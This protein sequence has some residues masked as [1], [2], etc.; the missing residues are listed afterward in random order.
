MDLFRYT[1]LSLAAL[2]VCLLMPREAQG[3]PITAYPY[4]ESFDASTSLPA[5]W[6]TDAGDGTEVW[7]VAASGA[8]EPSFGAEVDHTS[9]AGNLL[10]VDDSGPNN[11]INT[12]L[13]TPV[14][15][16]TGLAEPSLSFWYQNVREVRATPQTPSV[17]DVLVSTD[18]GATFGASELTVNTLVATWTQYTVDLSAYGASSNV[19]IQFRA[20]EAGAGTEAFAP[21]SD[22]S[23]DD[24]TVGE[25]PAGPEYAVTPTDGA[26]AVSLGTAGACAGTAS[27]SQTFSV[28][29]AGG[30]TLSVTGA[31][32]SGSGSF[33]VDDSALP[34]TLA[35]GEAV[36]IT[37]TFAP[38]TGV[39][40][41]QTA[42][43]TISYNDGTAS[44]DDI[45]LTATA[46]DANVSLGSG[47]GY[48]FV[49]SNAACTGAATTASP[50]ST[51]FIPVTGHTFIGSS[52]W[53]DGAG[54]DT[55]VT[56][57]A[58]TLDGLIGSI[59][60]FGETYETFGINSNG[61]ITFNPAYGAVPPTLPT[62]DPGGA[63]YVGV[64]NAA[65]TSAYDGDAGEVTPGV[66]YGLADANGDS[67]DDLVITYFHLYDYLAPIGTR[68][69]TAQ[70]IVYKGAEN[71]DDSFEIR[72]PGGLDA[73]GVAFQGEVF[74]GGFPP[75]NQDLEV[76]LGNAAGTAAA[77]YR[78]NGVGGPLFT[79][80]GVAIRFTPETQATVAAG[81]GWRMMAA[82]VEGFTVRRLAGMNLVQSVAGQYPDFS[83]DNVLVGYDGTDFVAATSESDALAPGQ[84][85]MWY[86]FDNDRDPADTDAGGGTSESYALPMLLQ[87]TGAETSSTPVSVPLL[88][89]TA[90]NWTMVGN[91]F[92]SDLDVS[93]IG[94][95]AQGGALAS[96]VGQVW[97]GT[98]W[99][100][101]T[102]PT[103][104]DKISAWQ[105]MWVESASATSLDIP[106]SAKTTGATYL[107][108]AAAHPMLVFSLDGQT[109]DGVPTHD[110]AVQLFLSEDAEA[111]WDV[112]DASKRTP[113]L[114]AYAT[115]SFEGDQDGAPVLKAQ[116]SR[117]VDA[118]SFEIPLAVEALGV[119]SD[120]V[121]TW[122]R[123]N[124][125][126]A[127][128]F[129][130]YDLLEETSV[131]L[132]TADQY[133]FRVE[134][135]A[136]RVIRNPM[137][138]LAPRSAES[139]RTGSVTRF[140]LRMN[141]NAVA[142][143]GAAP[144]EYALETA[145]PNPL[146]ESA[147][148]A[149][150]MPEAGPVS[151]AVYDLL[152]RQVAVLAEGERAAGRHVTTLEAGTLS[153]GVYVVRMQAGS[154][155]DA[156]RLTVVK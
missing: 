32:L 67:V 46:T 14:F 7:M 18:G 23:L 92:R 129:T 105:S 101:T 53:N 149:F 90:D 108:R 51:A 71:E 135:A 88:T 30:G 109:T 5:G 102:S 43:L 150:V 112:Y 79:D 110:A 70:L 64:M 93:D 119:E 56:I 138:L 91:P 123:T 21:Y 128:R 122:N 152:G 136:A 146:R 80:E 55:Y 72:Y 10:W 97:N 69:Y 118:T 96:T 45:S 144:T 58:T 145:R 16:L 113:M 114:A 59:R 143:A 115:L 4:A 40:G 126:E 33:S 35:G 42:T 26:G 137:D 22:P 65:I 36:G 2:A 151:V 106:A 85:F 50:T 57:D 98:G 8:T 41:T 140:V 100:L 83:D 48:A 62:A 154:F 9:G 125:P 12:G 29:N 155:A 75:V 74:S 78:V 111:G 84:G 131:D 103:L 34:A 142:A 11:A 28:S 148:I 116:E 13:F 25:A 134:P 141:T 87:G 153:A 3:Q 54:T 68:Y 31:T 104:G 44:T 19:V 73:E 124:L 17:L 133:A 107:Y 24:V 63:I 95:W 156:R 120:L 37:V 20:N 52:D 121:L 66:Y 139:R 60:F 81:A 15:D 127:W 94:A 61:A 132:Q 130:L 1:T 99:V 49:N 76:G 117:P 86:L 47:G 27:Q 77:V 38:D 89:G 39:T 6:Y 147:D 82:P